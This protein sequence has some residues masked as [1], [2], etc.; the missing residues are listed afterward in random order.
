[1][2][3]EII[4]TAGALISEA[5]QGTSVVFCIPPDQL[6]V[7]QDRLENELKKYQ[8]QMQS[9]EKWVAPFG[10]GLTLVI[11]FST[12][13]FRDALGVNAATWQGFFLLGI[14]LDLFWLAHSLSLLVKKKASIEDIVASLKVG[15][16][17][18]SMQPVAHSE[19]LTQLN[20]RN[21]TVSAARI[22]N[23]GVQCVK[24]GSNL[25]DAPAGQNLICTQ[26]GA[27]N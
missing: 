16:R 25:P 15:G 14:I 11:A 27:I 19:E 24:C 22:L 20:S 7:S 10:I 2:P 26:C 18:K 23:S 8:E 4:P 12:S 9:R 6:V 17:T 3:P 13:N 1:M 21:L 5:I